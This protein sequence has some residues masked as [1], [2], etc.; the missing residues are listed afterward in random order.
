MRALA[1]EIP[2]LQEEAV[3]LF[4]AIEQEPRWPDVAQRL[5]ATLDV[6]Q[7][8]NRLRELVGV[9]L[10]DQKAAA[11]VDPQGF[12]AFRV[13]REAIEDL[14][15]LVLQNGSLSVD[16]MRGFVAPHPRVPAV[17]INTNDDVRA[18]L[19]TMLHELAH[20][21]WQLPNESAYE[22][23]AATVLMPAKQF[24]ADVNRTP[25]KS[26]LEKVD[27]VARLYGITP[28]AVA[29]RMG[30]LQLVSWDEIGEVRAAIHERAGVGGRATGG[31]FYR[32][33]IVRMGPRF[34]GRVLDAVSES[35]ISEL[36]A[37]RVLGVRV[38]RFE[39]LRKELG[40]THVA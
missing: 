3:A 31:N 27:A 15:I 28:D 21:F 7:L 37:S 33:V 10:E 9:S 19:F 32:N 1:R 35:A 13:W 14:G 29:V 18:R 5:E 34:V 22:E 30:W 26:L 6:T 20:V 38:E 4:E 40:G 11:R 8:A 25:G 16:D 23:F 24:A 39:T 2:A 36:T 12:R 17:V